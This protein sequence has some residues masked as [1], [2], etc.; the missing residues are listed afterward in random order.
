MQELL[1]LALAQ[2]AIL[3]EGR[4]AELEPNA[5]RMKQ[6]ML[7]LAELDRLEPPRLA[8]SD[9]DHSI[10]TKIRDTALR[11]RDVLRGNAELLQNASEF[12]RF[13]LGALSRAVAE[14]NVGQSATDSSGCAAVLIDRKV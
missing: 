8:L 7:D 5:Q 12:V 2:R 1:R 10:R 3:V 9:G 13:T 6:V 11:L 14:Q 4:H